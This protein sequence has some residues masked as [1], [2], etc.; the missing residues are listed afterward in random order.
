MSL[1]KGPFTWKRLRR[2]RSAG[3]IIGTM[4]AVALLAGLTSTS[5]GQTAPL[6]PTAVAADAV[7]LVREAAAAPAGGA[8]AMLDSMTVRQLSL[9]DAAEAALTQ[10]YNILAAS[11][12]IGAARALVTQR[13]A[14]FDLNL[15]TA[16]N[17]TVRKTGERIESIGRPRTRVINLTEDDD[18]D[19]IPDFVQNTTS[20]VSEVDGERVPCV[21]ENGEVVNGGIGVGRCGQQPV[22]SVAKEAASL[23]TDA[24]KRATALVGVNK[25]F[26]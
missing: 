23:E 16:I 25:L 9:S 22:Y 15:S 3:R 13:A 7:A 14:A 4:T 11:E 20:T 26:S 2:L 17:Y 8:R 19:G 5:I 6:K 18:G 21:L 1:F 12:A 10:N 24:T